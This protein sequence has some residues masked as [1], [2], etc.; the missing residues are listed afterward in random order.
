IPRQSHVGRLSVSCRREV[1]AWMSHLQN[2]SGAKE[3][4]P[5]ARV[6]TDLARHRELRLEPFLFVLLFFRKIV[7]TWRGDRGELSCQRRPKKQA[8]SDSTRNIPREDGVL[9]TAKDL[10][11]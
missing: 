11:S 6:S 4:R 9:G 3:S 1:A 2:L 7:I 5:T 10:L 8:D